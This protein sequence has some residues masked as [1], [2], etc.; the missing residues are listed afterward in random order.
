MDTGRKLV[1]KGMGFE[2]QVEIQVETNNLW[3]YFPVLKI[4]FQ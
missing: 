2:G 4:K 3:I 1:T